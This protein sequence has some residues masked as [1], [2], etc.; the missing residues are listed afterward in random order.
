MRLPILALLLVASASFDRTK[1]GIDAGQL[2]GFDM[3][4]SMQIQ[5]EVAQDK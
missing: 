3:K 2:F 5:I 4:V 1:F